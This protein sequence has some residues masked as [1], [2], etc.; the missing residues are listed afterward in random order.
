MAKVVMRA[1]VEEFV[2]ESG[3]PTS[4]AIKQVDLLYRLAGLDYTLTGIGIACSYESKILR[5]YELD[6]LLKHRPGFFEGREVNADGMFKVRD[7]EYMLLEETTM[8][9]IVVEE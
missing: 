6:T 3:I 9:F 7:S 1:G 4:V 8:S 5:R 2:L